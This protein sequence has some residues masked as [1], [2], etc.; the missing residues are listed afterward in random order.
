MSDWA[1]E[2]LICLFTPSPVSLV[3][4]R[5][6]N[7]NQIVER[8]FSADRSF[9]NKFLVAFLFSFIGFCITYF[10]FEAVGHFFPTI[11]VIAIVMSA[12]YGG[13]YPSLLFALLLRLTDEVFF[14]P[15]GGFQFSTLEI[16]RLFISIGL[17]VFVSFLSSLLRDAFRSLVRVKQEADQA[18]KNADEAA[19]KAE[20][21]AGM[22]EKAL[23]LISHDI[24]NPLT[25]IGLSA[26]LILRS[27]GEV[28]KHQAILERIIHSAQYADSMIQSLLD[29]SRMRSGK[30]LP[31]EL[32]MSDLGVLVA[33]ALEEITSVSHHRVVFQAHEAIEG[34]WGATG[35]RRVLE[36][37]VTNAV[38]YGAPESP[39]TVSLHRVD[40]DAV[41]SVHNLGK[42]IPVEDQARLFD[43]FQQAARVVD[44]SVR[45]W[46]LGLAI[47]KGI[48]DAHGGSVRVESNESSGTT[49]FV[50]FPIRV[51]A[52][53]PGLTLAP[54]QDSRFSVT[55]SMVNGPNGV[56]N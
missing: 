37:L 45:G 11:G 20:D 33:K 35:I 4:M 25:A 49:F 12:L 29:V 14:L 34:A 40:Q 6:M 55:A 8:F 21:A 18:K 22:M 43:P 52:E 53:R 44:G 10:T 1:L 38:K 51:L 19:R 42:A 48:T 41:L 3:P 23:S 15:P 2:T 9:G 5:R 28:E 30:P 31:I 17:A 39:I 16:E 24:R 54:V 46:G 47:V 26:Q 36:N 27:P 13:I 56:K 32:K 7:F 50:K